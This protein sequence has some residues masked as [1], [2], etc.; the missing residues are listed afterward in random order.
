MSQQQPPVSEQPQP[1]DGTGAAAQPTSPAPGANRTIQEGRRG[2][3][4]GPMGAMGMPAEKAMAFWP[5]ARRLLGRLRPYRLLLGVT[6]VLA[7]VSTALMVT[8]PKLL[9]EATNVIFSGVIS[10]GIPAGM[11]KDEVIAA[12]RAN[13]QDQQADMIS[14]MVITPGQGIDFEALH[15]WLLVALAVYVIGSLLGWI[16]ALILNRVVQR[17]AYGLREEVELKLHKL[18]LKYF[19]GM[20][21]GELLS[22]VTNDVDNVQQSLNQTLSQILNSLL[23]VVG[24]VI[25]M[26]TIS[27]QLA[28]IA[29]VTVPLT[30]VVAG[31]IAK[32]SQPLFVEQWTRTGRLNAQ[33][34]EGYTGHALVKTFGRQ[35][36]VVERFREENEAMYRASFG[37]QFVSGIIMPAT[38]F[39]SN[40]VYVVI[41]VVGGVFVAGGT[42]SLGG[43]QAFI[44]YSRQ[45]GQ[46]LSQLGS[47]VN[48]LQSGVASAERVF[49]LLDAAEQRPDPVNP[50]SPP[51]DAAEL[52]FD[53]VDFDYEADKPLIRDLTLAAAPGS[54]VAIVGPTGAGKSTL[55][56]LLMRFYEV[57]D[58]RILLGGVDVADMTRDDL[59][60]RTGMV[61]QDTWLFTG[62]IRENIRYGRPDASDEEVVEAARAAYVDHFVAAL[63]D[64]YDTVLADE[65]DNVSAGQKQLITIARAVLADPRILI[66]D[67]ATSSVDTRTELLIQRAMAELRVDR[68]S[69]VIAHRLST[70][71]DA[72]LILV[73]EDGRIVEQG[74]HDS[75]VAADGAYARLYR[76]QFERAATE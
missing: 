49:D 57:D 55:V 12:M 66:L 51:A 48:L 52:A 54:T 25:M 20:A 4:H 70:I 44:Q 24:V 34:E 46:P 7:A 76:S 68:T 1:V 75:L 28:I 31:L 63:P 6:I 3:P 29:L 41:A 11:T 15:T 58:G 14:T 37:A 30:A 22:R 61:L 72:H 59:R 21:R 38:M 45:L 10:K 42:M 71:R 23:M 26:C 27:W 13:G 60:G 9:G 53:D 35:R 67:E 65:G 36:E 74:D 5:S 40:L 19:D 2:A 69:F 47:M 50:E 33:V 62:T 16:Q 43:V 56:N 64:G 39:I 17:V 8:G 18:P 73:M 32:R